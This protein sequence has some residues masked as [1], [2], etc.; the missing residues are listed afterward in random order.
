MVDNA[1]QILA[2]LTIAG[3]FLLVA[4]LL[5]IYGRQHPTLQ[6][7]FQLLV[8]H[9]A[10]WAWVVALVAMLGSLFYSE[11]IGY[12]PCKLCW[13]QRIFMYP[14]AVILALSWQRRERVALFYAGWLA[15][16]GGVVAAYHYTMQRGLLPSAVCS[17]TGAADCSREYV[18]AFDYV[19][20]PLMSL[21]AFVLIMVLVWAGWKWGK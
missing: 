6:R 4:I 10:L 2:A 21:T 17:I 19:T 14:L 15:L 20:I 11:V 7:W 1:N 5:L 8:D 18:F 12:E 3:Q 9:A 16:L 13:W